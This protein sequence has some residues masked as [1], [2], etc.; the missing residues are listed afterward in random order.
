M[1]PR[2]VLNI[3]LTLNVEIKRILPGGVGLA[4]A[5][6]LTIFVPLAAPGD[7]LLVDI[8]RTRGKVAFALIKEIINPSPVRIEP[9]CPYFGRCGGC[10]FHSLTT[11]SAPTKWR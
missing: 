9:P 5:E 1:Y 8:D 7:T 4:H 11:N 2:L 3:Q 6:G 10:D